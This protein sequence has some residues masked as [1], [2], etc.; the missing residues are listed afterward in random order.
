MQ[1][2]IFIFLITFFTLQACNTTSSN[3][4]NSSKAEETSGQESTQTG[5]SSTPKLEELSKKRI[6]ELRK[7]A[8]KGADASKITMLKKRVEVL[9]NQ[10]CKCSEIKDKK[11]IVYCQSKIEQTYLGIYNRQKGDDKKDIAT[12]YQ[13]IIDACK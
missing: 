10:Y 6:E 5:D 7:E 12:T 9:A 11:R 2:I 1:K 3:D 8:K 13:S 4:T